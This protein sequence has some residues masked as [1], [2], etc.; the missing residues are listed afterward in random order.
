[1]DGNDASFVFKS[2]KNKLSKREE[3]RFQ[4]QNIFK[5]KKRFGKYHQFFQ[6]HKFGDC[7]YLQLLYFYSL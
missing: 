2:S 5:R 3:P 6:E 4:K 7:K 1:M